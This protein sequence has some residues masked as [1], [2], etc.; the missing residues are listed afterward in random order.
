M[1]QDPEQEPQ[2]KLYLLGELPL[3]E[4]VLI[5]QRL[6]L[7]TDYAQ[8]AQSIEDDLIDDYVQDNLTAVEREKFETHFLKIPEHRADLKIARAF[9]RHL[10]S[11]AIPPP[12]QIV[13][14]FS[15]S[16]QPAMALHEAGVQS[17]TTGLGEQRTTFLA[18]PPTRRSL[19]WFALAAAILIVLSIIT[20]IAVRSISRPVSDRLEAQKPPAVP[21]ESAKQQQ[22]GPSIPVNDNSGRRGETA[23]RQSGTDEPHKKSTNDRPG[24]P[25]EQQ[26]TPATFV[27]VTIYPGGTSRGGGQTNQ[28]TIKSGQTDVDLKLPLPATENHERYRLE[29]LSRQRRIQVQTLDSRRDELGRVVFVRFP[30]TLLTQKRY[31]M[32]LRGI[33]TDGRP[34]EITSYFFTVRRQP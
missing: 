19:V 26:P 32:K 13:L 33:N 12:N 30:A 18:K 27:A 34:G 3:E 15:N 21:T 25:P 5:E 22:P 20:W 24:R 7:D 8:L 2:I 23:Q 9:Q 17:A 29:L 16:D 28:V 14:A 11:E 1:K 4:Q 10:A 6:F 31:E